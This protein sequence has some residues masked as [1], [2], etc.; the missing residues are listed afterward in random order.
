MIIG[1]CITII[2][3][4]VIP[5]IDGPTALMRSRRGQRTARLSRFR[6]PQ[7]AS[8]SKSS[9]QSQAMICSDERVDREKVCIAARL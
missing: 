6:H 1:S 8:A 4:E 3:R 9:S 2:E 7:T 5:A